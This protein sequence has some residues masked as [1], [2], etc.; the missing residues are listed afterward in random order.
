MS[1]CI[2]R[3]SNLRQLSD[4]EVQGVAKAMGAT[5]VK[6]F[7]D[8]R[9]LDQERRFGQEIWQGL[10]AVM[11]ALIFLELILEQVFARRKG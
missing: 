3:W 8:Y 6:T 1:A 7:N 10:L 4:A 5:V 9:S 2:R 11:V